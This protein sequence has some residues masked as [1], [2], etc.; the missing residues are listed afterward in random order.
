MEKNNLVK[1]TNKNVRSSP[2]KIALLLDYIRG[3]NIS[4]INYLKYIYAFLLTSFPL[5]DKHN[6]NEID[7]KKNID[8]SKIMI[9]QIVKF[10]TKSQINE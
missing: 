4:N 1:S 2:R 3:K 5:N 6:T 7:F 8:S 9:N 10:I